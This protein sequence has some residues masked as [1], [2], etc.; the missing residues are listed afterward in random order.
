MQGVVW[1]G[2]NRY[3][4]LK[5]RLAIDLGRLEHVAAKICFP[6]YRNPIR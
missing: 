3:A 5:L 1:S 6:T 2:Q 4:I